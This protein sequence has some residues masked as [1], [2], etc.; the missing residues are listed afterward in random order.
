VISITDH[1]LSYWCDDG[2]R[3]KVLTNPKFM[4]YLLDITGTSNPFIRE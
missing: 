1:R 3:P 4:T 2:K